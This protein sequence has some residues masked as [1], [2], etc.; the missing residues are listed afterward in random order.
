MVA[1]GSMACPAAGAV[2]VT[3][4]NFL[5]GPM[6]SLMA[7]NSDSSYLAT[8]S[9][10]G[11]VIRVHHTALH[12]L[13]EVRSTPLIAITFHLNLLCSVCYPRHQLPPPPSWNEERVRTQASKPYCF[14]RGSSVA[15][16]QSLAFS[17]PAVQ[18]TL[19]CSSSDHGTV[20]LFRIE[21]PPR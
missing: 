4:P 9:S 19:L 6:Q 20:H 11:T 18:P 17:P 21:A 3:W 1:L 8:A 16:I 15:T 7:F 2:R 10:K 5:H 12:L 13:P 14:R